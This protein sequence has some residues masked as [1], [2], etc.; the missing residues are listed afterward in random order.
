[1]AQDNVQSE[2][3]R[4]CDLEQTTDRLR[5]QLSSL[6][7]ATV[8]PTETAP[9]IR[10]FATSLESDGRKIVSVP[11]SRKGGRVTF[12]HKCNGEFVLI[13][14][15]NGE[16]ETLAWPKNVGACDLVLASL[17]RT[18]SITNTVTLGKEDSIRRYTSERGLS[19]HSIGFYCDGDKEKDCILEF[20]DD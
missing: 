17:S 20:D 1:M 18:Q 7:A 2:H 4:I 15:P 10:G 9:L 6:I 12:K 14:K 5:T 16:P 3:E 19:G 13:S 11:L 8:R